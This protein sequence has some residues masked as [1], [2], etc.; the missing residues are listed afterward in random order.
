MKTIFQCSSFFNKGSTLSTP[1]NSNKSRNRVH[2]FMDGYAISVVNE[3]VSRTICSQ[4]PVCDSL[5]A[6]LANT[7]LYKPRTIR[8]KSG[9]LE[10]CSR[11]PRTDSL[12]TLYAIKCFSENQ[13]I[14]V[15]LSTRSRALLYAFCI[16][17]LHSTQ[18]VF[19]NKYF[20]TDCNAIMVNLIVYFIE[21][22]ETI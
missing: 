5:N 22:V 10:K 2:I 4:N 14:Y 17:R 7:A 20:H 15:S 6:V 18:T 16:G 11:M 21:N 3:S 12:T 13:D 9:S 19:S 8:E 1:T